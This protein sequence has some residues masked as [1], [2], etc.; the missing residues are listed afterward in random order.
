M[1]TFESYTIA[2]NIR[3]TWKLN[4]KR[5]MLWLCS[6]F[7]LQIKR[8]WIY[9]VRLLYIDSN[10]QGNWDITFNFFTVSSIIGERIAESAGA[11]PE[12]QDW[13]L[14]SPGRP[15]AGPPSLHGSEG[16]RCC[17]LPTGSAGTTGA[18]G[19]LPADAW[20]VPKSTHAI[21]IKLR[22]NF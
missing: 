9:H 16:M 13:P 7:N 17:R 5:D 6:G 8:R 12:T 4:M 20:N 1:L 22:K 3:R 19:E 18:T 14:A 2:Y 10:F 11:A 21:T 15:E